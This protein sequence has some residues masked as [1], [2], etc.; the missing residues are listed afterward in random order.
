MVS[1]TK[2]APTKTTRIFY[3]GNSRRTLQREALGRR[4]LR[5]AA[6]GTQSITNFFPPVVNEESDAN[7][8]E[9]SEAENL[10]M[11]VPLGPERVRRRRF[12]V[13]DTVRAKIESLDAFIAYNNNRRGMDNMQKTA[14][15]AQS[16]LL[17]M[18]YQC[19]TTNAYFELILMGATKMAAAKDV[20]RQFF[21]IKRIRSQSY[22]YS[23]MG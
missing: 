20:V 23:R 16:N 11:Q 22:N 9:D 18:I 14:K 15:E 17:H 3:K 12:F 10:V 7:S 13:L 1:A 5:S 21:W 4:Q 6:V 8:D 19:L 2:Y